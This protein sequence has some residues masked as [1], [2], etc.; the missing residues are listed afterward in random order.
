MSC[1][2]PQSAILKH[3]N[4]EIHTRNKICLKE[5]NNLVCM[6]MATDEGEKGM[7]VYD[8]THPRKLQST[9]RSKLF[10]HA[11]W[12]LMG[13][14][15]PFPTCKN[16]WM[17]AGRWCTVYSLSDVSIRLL[18]ACTTQL[19]MFVLD[20]FQPNMACT[21]RTSSDCCNYFLTYRQRGCL[22]CWSYTENA[23]FSTWCIQRDAAD[24]ILTHLQVW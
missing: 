13:C 18:R 22:R 12:H 7:D 10:T 9:K 1:S 2:T 20:S 14:V 16:A 5:I 17:A 24:Y 15:C 23:I 11:S 6:I 21:I 19:F 4:C 8:P 3:Q